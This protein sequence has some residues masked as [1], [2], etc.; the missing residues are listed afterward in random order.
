M[1]AIHVIPARTVGTNAR[2]LVVASAAS[3]NVIRASLE[4]IV[5]LYAQGTVRAIMTP[6]FATVDGRVITAKFPSVQMTALE[7]AYATVPF[8]YVSVIRGGKATTAAN[9]TAQASRIVIIGGHVQ[10]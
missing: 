8:S 6:V 2:A 10:R 9:L 5:I 4:R 7:M 3:A 1:C